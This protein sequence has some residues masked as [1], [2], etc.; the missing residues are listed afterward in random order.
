MT[1]RK[2]ELAQRL[3]RDFDACD[4]HVLR[5][6]EALAGLSADVPLSAEV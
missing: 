2:E 6:R 3:Q 5:I 4:R 1:G